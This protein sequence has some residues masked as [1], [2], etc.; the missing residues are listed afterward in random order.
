VALSP[1]GPVTVI[2]SAFM[3]LTRPAIVAGTIS[4]AAATLASVE[5]G[6]IRTFSPGA[7]LAAVVLRRNFVISVE[8]LI[9]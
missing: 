4:I 9:T 8:E 6:T 3:A 7:R 5:F 2:V 1:F